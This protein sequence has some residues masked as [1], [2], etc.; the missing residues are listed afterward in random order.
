MFVTSNLHSRLP[1]AKCPPPGKPTSG[2]AFVWMIGIWMDRYLD[3]R[4]R[5]M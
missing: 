3:L 2:A 1:H 5:P 4:V